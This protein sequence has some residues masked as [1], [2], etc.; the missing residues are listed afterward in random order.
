[1]TE[2]LPSH[3]AQRID[4]TRTV[5]FTFAGRSYIGFAGDTVGSALYAAGVRIFSR[6]FKYHRP[7]GLLCCR[8][9]CPNCLV[10][11]D[12]TPNVRACTEPLRDGQLVAPQ[13]AWPSLERDALAVL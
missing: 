6:S 3:P 11:I 4:R 10:N 13:H 9:H 12:G 5:G 2:R 8:G 7:R 1:M